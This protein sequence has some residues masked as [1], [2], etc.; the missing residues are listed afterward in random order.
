MENIN[1]KSTQIIII[2]I[3]IYMF[4]LEQGSKWTLTSLWKYFR[5][6][7]VDPEPIWKKSIKQNNFFNSNNSF[8]FS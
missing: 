6:V 7:G 2:I 1:L 8:L 3:K 4:T 5:A